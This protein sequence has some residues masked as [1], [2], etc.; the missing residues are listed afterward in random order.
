ML[1]FSASKVDTNMRD[2][3]EWFRKCK[4]MQKYDEHKQETWVVALVCVFSF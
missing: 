2:F 4:D 3:L 1:M